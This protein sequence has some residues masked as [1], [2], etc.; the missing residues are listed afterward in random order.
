ML[1]IHISIV[2][3]AAILS[4]SGCVSMQPDLPV[5][6]SGIPDEWTLTTTIAPTDS[7]NKRELD[8][9]SGTGWQEF[10]TDSKLTSLIGLALDNNRDLKTAALNIER[11]R[12]LYR[13]QRSQSLPSI[14][15]SAYMTRLGGDGQANVELYSAEVG[16][17]SYELDLFGRIRS[18]KDQALN[19]YLATEQA[20]NSARL[21]LVAEIA[22]AYT[23]LAADMELHDLARSTLSLYE[24]E[25]A[26][27]RRRYELG[28]VSSLDLNQSRTI[29]ANAK[30]DVSLYEGQVARDLSALNLLAGTMVNKD[31]LPTGFSAIADS[32][33]ALPAGIPSTVLLRRPD[34]QQAEKMLMAAN[35]NIG[36][37]RAAMF[38]SI[39]LTGNLGFTSA[40]LDGLFSSGTGT[41]GFMPQVS[42]PIFQGGRLQANLDVAI[43]DRDI[44]LTSYEKAIQQGF[45]EVTDALALSRTLL[46]RRIALE[47][48]VAAARD[49]HELSQ[50]RYRAGQDSYLLLLDAQRTLYS[51]QQAFVS[52]LLNEQVNLINLYKVLGG[53]WND[54]S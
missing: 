32:M 4:L 11:A 1:K 39:T 46:N 38:P 28:A 33:V 36:A 24:E 13:I 16:L 52:S 2:T 34:I 48:Y 27:T 35:A 30:A 22:N 43:V 23:T 45:K 25:L 7:L 42:I 3:L 9:I 5:A 20:L 40:E 44:A 18:L 17:V 31:L 37:A 53:G 8:E 26:L 29:V 6:K 51:A 21:S 10:F 12:A 50:K 47:E 15:A 19:Q 14:A 54:K 41:W 49:T